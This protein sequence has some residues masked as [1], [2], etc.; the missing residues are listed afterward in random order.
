MKSPIIILLS[1]F[2]IIFSSCRERIRLNLGDTYKRLVVEGG[3]TNDTMVHT[4]ILSTTMNYLGNDSIVPY[5]SNLYVTITEIETGIVTVLTENDT[6]PGHYQ[7]QPNYFGI[8]GYNYRLDIADVV[9]EE[10]GEPENYTATAFCPYIADQI[11]SI[12]CIYGKNILLN[13]FINFDVDTTLTHFVSD[14]GWNILFYAQD[15]PTRE[16]YAFVSYKNGIA[17]DDSLKQLLTLPDDLLNTQGAYFNGFPISFLPN[18]S[19]AK[20]EIG[21]TITLEIRSLTPAYYNYINEFVDVMGG[22]NP[23]FGSSP[24]NVRGNVSGGAIGFFYAYCNRK[25]SIVL[26]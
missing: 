12:K 13:A 11:D 21:D 25:K 20:A 23:F 14:S 19:W 26:E 16:F 1:T 24:A 2:L 4:V 17:I 5:L 15:P 3:V 6:M 8:Q 9:L 10:D 22:S 18:S 7:T